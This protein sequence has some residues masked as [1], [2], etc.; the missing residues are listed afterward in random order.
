MSEPLTHDDLIRF[1][2]GNADE[3]EDVILV[4]DE[5]IAFV[6]EIWSSEMSDLTGPIMRA[7]HLER[8]VSESALAAL[9]TGT[10]LFR[11]GLQYLAGPNNEADAEHLD[12][13]E[14]GQ[15]VDS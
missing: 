11:A 3:L 9:D 15:E 4:D 7:I 5:Y 2:Y 8:L 6:E 14:A 10:R 13:Y 12:D 1:A